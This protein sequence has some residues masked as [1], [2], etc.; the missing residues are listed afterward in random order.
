MIILIRD[1]IQSNFA[2]SPE[3]GDKVYNLL[4]ERLS[5]KELTVLSFEGLDQITTAFLNNAIA[6]LYNNFSSEQLNKYLKITD[7]DTYDKYLLKKV[8]ER[9]KLKLQDDPET[10]EG[11]K[12]E[13]GNE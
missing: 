2:V 8:I 10:L 1:V 3:N 7:L 5:N 6:K 13:F 4:K 11:I 9:A 12:G